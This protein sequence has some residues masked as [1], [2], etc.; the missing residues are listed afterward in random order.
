MFHRGGELA[1]VIG[2]VGL[3][4]TPTWS[5]T[6]LRYRGKR[7]ETTGLKQKPDSTPVELRRHFFVTSNR[8][9]SCEITITS[10]TLLSIS[11]FSTL[12][13]VAYRLRLGSFNNNERR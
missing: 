4:G 3:S 9:R 13:G 12:I 7:L 2:H 6:T 5:V 8:A 10:H 1:L 11:V